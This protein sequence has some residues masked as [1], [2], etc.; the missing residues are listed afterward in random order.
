[1][2]CSTL[3]KEVVLSLETLVITYRT[4]RCHDSEDCAL[5]YHRLLVFVGYITYAESI[6]ILVGASREN[7]GLLILSLLFNDALKW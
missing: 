7:S 6:S 4:T 2:Y 3:N 1:M 5:T